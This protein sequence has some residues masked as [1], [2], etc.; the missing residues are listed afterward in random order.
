MCA[1]C[2]LVQNEAG[3]RRPTDTHKGGGTTARRGKQQQVRHGGK[4]GREESAIAGRTKECMGLASQGPTRGGL[5]WGHVFGKTWSDTDTG[6]F[7]DLLSLTTVRRLDGGRGQ[8][9]Q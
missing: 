4:E 7:E 6:E 5:G 3:R 1:P 2:C 8:P 9:Q